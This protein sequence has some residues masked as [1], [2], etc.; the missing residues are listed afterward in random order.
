LE[1]VRITIGCG[2]LPTCSRCSVPSEQE[3]RLLADVTADIESAVVTS[4]GRSGVILLAG[5][6]AFSHPSLPQIIS[7]ATSAGA[8]R[9]AVQTAGG[10]LGSGGNAQGVL[11]AGVRH[12]EI[13]YLPGDDA[14]LAPGIPGALDGVAELIRVSAAAG[15]R[16]ALSAVITACR[17]TIQ[18]LS[19]AVGQ[20]AAAGVGAVHIEVDP[21][22]GTGP[23]ATASV[24]AAC[25][26]GVVNAV[27][28]DVS[29]FALPESH[30]MHFAPE[31]AS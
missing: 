9:I 1:V 27:W 22:A 23:S 13:H 15:A 20:L 21:S 3:H 18:H 2:G 10:L 17:H 14:E 6:E 29:G 7:A 31:A 19:P 5:T 11:H 30:S 24:L 25:D 12:F 26:T 8:R 16:I 4:V 28:V